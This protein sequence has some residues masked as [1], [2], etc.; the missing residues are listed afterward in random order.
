MARAGD[1]LSYE[2]QKNIFSPYRD[3]AQMVH[4]GKPEIRML[5]IMD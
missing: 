3:F 4:F 2:T 5:T 1:E